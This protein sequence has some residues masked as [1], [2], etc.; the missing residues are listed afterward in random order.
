[1]SA[2]TVALVA[3][4]MEI[5]M[6]GHTVRSGSVKRQQQCNRVGTSAQPHEYTRSRGEMPFKKFFDS[7]FKHILLSFPHLRY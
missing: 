3:T 7:I 4:Q 6:R 2:I 5:A 1:M